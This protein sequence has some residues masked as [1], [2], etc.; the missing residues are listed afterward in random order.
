MKQNIV[1]AV[2][3]AALYGVVFY[4]G[5]LYGYRGGEIAAAE[6]YA[7][8]IKEYRLALDNQTAVV[9]KALDLKA[10]D[11]TTQVTSLLKDTQ[12]IRTQLKNQPQPLVVV[13]E[14]DCKA[15]DQLLEARRKII[16]R[17]NQ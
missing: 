4:A 14:G 17:A 12:Q 15:S 3:F 1:I 2:L 7:K 10:V 8:E 16:E 5:N 11:L 9:N 13:Q 6:T